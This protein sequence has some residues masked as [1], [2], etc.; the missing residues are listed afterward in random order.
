MKQLV[1]AAACFAILY[2][3]DAIWFG[4]WYFAAAKSAIYAFYV[5][6]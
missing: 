6:W 2:G 5:R 1:A 3:V 4:G